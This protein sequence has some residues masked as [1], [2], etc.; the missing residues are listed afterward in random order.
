M[1]TTALTTDGRFPVR[2]RRPNR[3][4]VDNAFANSWCPHYG[5]HFSFDQ[6]RASFHHLIAKSRYSY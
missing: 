5:V 2:R 1:S 4:S 6:W 3:P